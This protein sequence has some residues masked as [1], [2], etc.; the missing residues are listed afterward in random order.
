MDIYEDLA[1]TY[2]RTE[3]WEIPTNCTI[4]ASELRQASDGLIEI[5]RDWI[6][7]LANVA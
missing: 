3:H 7:R 4:L 5:Y 1:I 6:W 2:C